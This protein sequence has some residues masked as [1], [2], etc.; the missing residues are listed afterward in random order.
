[1]NKL[2]ILTVGSFITG[3]IISSLNKPKIGKCSPQVEEE[4]LAMSKKKGVK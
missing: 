2:V 4:L 3:A 1:M